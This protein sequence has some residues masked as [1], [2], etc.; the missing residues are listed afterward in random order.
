M[1]VKRL[2]INLYRNNN[3][4]VL[5]APCPGFEPGNFRIAVRGHRLSVSEDERGPG[6]QRIT[7]LRQEWT[8]GPH[9]RAV[10]LPVPVDASRANATYDNGVLVVI[11]PVADQG[12]SG[13][14]TMS[15]AGTAKGRRVRHVGRDLRAKA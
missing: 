12:T 14:I 2:P 5:T 7:H 6:Q 15:K 10:N 8:T 1:R 9:R 3:R 11:L 13:A 4:L